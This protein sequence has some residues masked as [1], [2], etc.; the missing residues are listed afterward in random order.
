MYLLVF[1]AA[2][3]ANLA[4][5]NVAKQLHVRLCAMIE[6]VIVTLYKPLYGVRVY[7]Y[8]GYIS[9]CEASK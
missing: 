9:A 1:A 8:R 6:V 3:E 5:F 4:I 7:Q 2:V